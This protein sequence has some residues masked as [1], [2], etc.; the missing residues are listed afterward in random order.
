MKEILDFLF[1]FSG[2]NSAMDIVTGILLLLLALTAIA[3]T[4]CSIMVLILMSQVSRA[5]KRLLEECQK[6]EEY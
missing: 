1:N 3:H 2:E 6:E 4:F 5:R